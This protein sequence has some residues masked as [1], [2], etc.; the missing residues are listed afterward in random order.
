VIDV[1]GELE[2]FA[3]YHH[4]AGRDDGSVWVLT[5]LV[6]DLADHTGDPL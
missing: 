5:I 6:F 3:G 4:D 2:A 1:S